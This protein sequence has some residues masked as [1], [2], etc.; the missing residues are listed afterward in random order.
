MR[1][2]RSST[3]SVRIS[4]AHRPP[5]ALPRRIPPGAPNS[6]PEPPLL[7]PGGGVSY[8]EHLLPA[9]RRRPDLLGAFGPGERWGMSRRRRGG[10]DPPLGFLPW[11]QQAA[12]IW[13][14][15]DVDG[16]NAG[17]E[18]LKTVNIEALTDEVVYL[19]PA[20]NSAGPVWSRPRAIN[21]TVMA[22]PIG[23]PRPGAG[24]WPCS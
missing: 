12:M 1:A 6:Y 18:T 21:R 16:V 23:F 10:Q 17:K 4:R 7:S 24:R 22:S 14:K 11:R 15:R 20:D 5:I 8:L 2:R 9:F 19:S 13:K 3:A